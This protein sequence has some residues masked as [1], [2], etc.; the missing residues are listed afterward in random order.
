MRDLE[1]ISK[2][3]L[4]IYAHYYYPDVAS[5]GQLLTE[6][7]EEMT[8][9]FEVT[10]I[11]AVPSYD[12][13]IPSRYLQGKYF[14]EEHNG[15]QILRVS[16][17]AFCKTD[18]SSRVK[19]ILI[20]FLRS[21]WATLKINHIDCILSCSQPP[22]LGDLLGVWGKWFKHARLVSME[23][24]WNPEQIVCAKAGKNKVFIQ[25][26][27]LLDKFA[28]SQTDMVVTVGR[29]L[30]ETLHNRFAGHN[31]RII[32]CP[33]V[34]L[35]HNWIDEK[36]IFPLSNTD[37]NVVLF[38]EKYKLTNKFIIMY[39]GNLG[40]YYDLEGL[41]KVIERFRPGETHSVDGREVVFVFVGAGSVMD[42]MKQYT[43]V[44]KMN[45]VSFIPYQKKEDLI[46]SL[47]AG[48]VHWCVNAKGIKG[49][50]CPSKL[51]GIMAVGKPVLGVL[52]KAAEAEIIVRE[53]GCGILCE[54]GD[55]K[56]IAENIGRILKLNH[57]E[58]FR[59]GE[60]GRKYLKQKLTKEISI[61]KYRKTLLGE[62]L[63]K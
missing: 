54:P 58:L 42:K 8:D 27:L 13:Q 52:E 41:L 12:G 7:A 34:E 22:I 24:D 1:G 9:C 57:T 45:N 3:R 2:K 35:I 50:S 26:L 31:G 4:L 62:N 23:Q 16:V 43:A 20:Y 39:S 55:Y 10:V 11:C 5:T 44:H 18:K 59:M 53:S 14:K 61:E 15:V 48:D 19:N 51:Y 17:P 29:D 30:V 49:I 40:L 38:K 37:R 21:M 28:N 25:V 63:D 46:Y 33:P 56:G 47:N 6:L 36:K 32:K 60:N